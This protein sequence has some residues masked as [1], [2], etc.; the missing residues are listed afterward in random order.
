MLYNLRIIADD[1]GLDRSIN[2]GII[3]LLKNNHISGASLMANGEAFDD[4]V[5]QCSGANFP[6][7]GIHLVLV[8]ERSLTGMMLPRSHRIFFIKYI[9]TIE[10]ILRYIP[11]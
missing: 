7:I 3:Y 1:L 5:A 4:A 2:E 11:N 10:N 9:F 6:G 8:E